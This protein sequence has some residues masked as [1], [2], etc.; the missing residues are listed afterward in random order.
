MQKCTEH[1]A[2][3]IAVIRTLYCKQQEPAKAGDSENGIYHK[4][5]MTSRT[6]VGNAFGPGMA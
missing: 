2:R 5:V 1:L 3:A 4:G 6:Q